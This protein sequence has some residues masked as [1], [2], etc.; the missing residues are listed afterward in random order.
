MCVLFRATHNVPYSKAFPVCVRVQ[1]AP[2]YRIKGA[3]IRARCCPY[4]CLT[5]AS[6]ASRISGIKGQGECVSK[7]N[8]Q[9]S[10]SALSKRNGQMG[11]QNRRYALI[12]G[13]EHQPYISAIYGRD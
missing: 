3:N 6:H 4:R 7:N 1:P 5:A 12:H 11:V 10:V 2:G 8:G 13:V 9:P